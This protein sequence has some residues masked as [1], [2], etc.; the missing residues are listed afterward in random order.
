MTT[1][2]DALRDLDRRRTQ[3]SWKH[4][5]DSD[6][7]K[8]NRHE[9]SAWGKTVGRV[10][11]TKG[12]ED[13]DAANATLLSCADLVCQMG[14]ALQAAAESM[15]SHGGKTWIT[16]QNAR[17]LLAELAEKVKPS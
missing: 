6:D 17:A 2:T 1:L 14:I 4:Y 7:G 8:T 11:C 3:G 9:I 12:R 10:Y 5:D 15:E 16:C 13:Q